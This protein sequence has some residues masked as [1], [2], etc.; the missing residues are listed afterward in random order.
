MA[1]NGLRVLAMAYGPQND[2]LTFAGIV[3]MHDPPR[4]GVAESIHKLHQGGIQVLM[5][6]GDSK[7]TALF[8]AQ[9]CGITGSKDASNSSTDGKPE[10]QLVSSED[11]F[12]SINAL[13]GPELDSMMESSMEDDYG[14][15]H[16]RIAPVKVFYRCTPRHKLSIVEALQSHGEIVAMTGDG[17]NDCT[18]LKKADIGIAMGARGTDVAKEA[19]DIILIED[20]FSTIPM[21]VSEGK[22]I[23]YNIQ[24]FLSF[25]LTTSFSALLLIT[26]TTALEWPTPLNAM[27]ILWINIV[28]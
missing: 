9:Q 10:E 17:V 5:V 22:G 25:Q 7:E 18:A 16:N 24:K 15:L 11:T 2:T 28:S 20:D 23:F 13:S 27:Q 6:T 12:S 3:G 4:D 8:I 26:I 1:S 21:A 19:A 14:M